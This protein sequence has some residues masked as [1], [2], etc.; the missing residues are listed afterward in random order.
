MDHSKLKGMDKIM[1]SMLTKGLSAQ[2][3]RSPRD[4]RMLELLNTDASYVSEE[5][6]KDILNWYEANQVYDNK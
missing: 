5:N 1:I 4:E 3:E 6:L 2:K